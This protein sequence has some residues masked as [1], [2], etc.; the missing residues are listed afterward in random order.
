MRNTLLSFAFTGIMAFPLVACDVEDG[1][2]ATDATDTTQ[3]ETDATTTDT[4]PGDTIQTTEYFAVIVDDSN[5]FPTHRVVG[6]DPCATASSPLNAHGADIDAVGLFDG[7]S[8]VGYFEF[9]DYQMG[10]FCPN[11][12]NT[13]TDPNQA[14]GAP[15]ATLT[16]RFVSLV[17]GFLIGEFQGSPV[18]QS[19]DIITVY[20][21]GSKCGNN[22]SCGGVDEGYEVFVAEDL[23]CVNT[24]NYPYSSCAIKLSNTAKGESN[25]PVTG[26]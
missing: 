1:G 25:I 24:A 17:G 22:T 11:K 13:M 15:N 9:V 2:D 20:E 26:F 18:I 6:T 3:T 23:D 14:L 8:L 4:G 12:A 7:A 21:V 16:E 10:N 19:G 5:I